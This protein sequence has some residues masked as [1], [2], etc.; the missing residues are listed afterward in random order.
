[1][2]HD[3]DDDVKISRCANSRR[4][5]SRRTCSAPRRP[6]LPGSTRS[7][8]SGS[9]SSCTSSLISRTALAAA[10][11]SMICGSHRSLACSCS[12]HS[13]ISGGRMAVRFSDSHSILACSRSYGSCN[14]SCAPRL[15]YRP[16][17]TE[18]DA[19]PQ[20][21]IAADVDVCPWCPH[22]PA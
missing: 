15:M 16:C 17:S 7:T 2:A 8:S 1:V 11:A 22:L 5:D 12:R 4:S 18:R 6:S 20:S 9:G 10:A 14:R 13:R 21:Q 3:V 19:Y